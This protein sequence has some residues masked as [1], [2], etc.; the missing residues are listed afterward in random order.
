VTGSEVSTV[1][2]YI[3]KGHR[4]TDLIGR[5]TSQPALHRRICY[6]IPRY[7]LQQIAQQASE[8]AH[9]PPWSHAQPF[10]SHSQRSHT[11]ISQHE[12]GA[13][14]F[15]DPK[16]ANNPAASNIRVAYAGT[17]LEIIFILPLR[18]R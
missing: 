4:P 7:L 2:G 14:G 3:Q 18:S 11:Q 1:N 8:Q 5:R 9:S 15:A 12:H 16:A 17:D 6:D 13:A 10:A